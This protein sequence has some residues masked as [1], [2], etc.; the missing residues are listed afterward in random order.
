MVTTSMI[1]F[2]VVCLVIYFKMD[3]QKPKKKLKMDNKIKQ[4]TEKKLSV[5]LDNMI[6]CKSYDRLLT[7]QKWAFDIIDPI[8]YL[9]CDEWEKNVYYIELK[10]K[11]DQTYSV[12]ESKILYNSVK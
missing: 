5:V 7:T 6:K 3:N 1:I 8:N 11:I 9:D 2:L 4:N 10:T 12:T